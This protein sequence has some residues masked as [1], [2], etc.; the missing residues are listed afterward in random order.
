MAASLLTGC[1]HTA[2]TR[3]NYHLKAGY[4]PNP[5]TAIQIAEAVLIPIYGKEQ[6]ESERPFVANLHGDIWTVA[7]SLPEGWL[8]GVA[9]VEIRKSDGNVM[10]V[11]HGE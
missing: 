11:I 4:V 5:E 3:D 6:I 7:G 2:R 8:G 9:E 1:Q 10:R